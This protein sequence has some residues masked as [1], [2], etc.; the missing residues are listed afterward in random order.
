MEQAYQTGIDLDR[1]GEEFIGT[2]TTQFGKGGTSLSGSP[3]L[4]LADTRE[5]ID[6]NIERVVEQGRIESAALM[7]M[8]K[9]AEKASKSAKLSGLGQTIAAVGTAA[10]LLA[11]GPFALIGL[12]GGLGLNVAA[13]RK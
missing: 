5:R 2:I 4:V 3:L 8:A 6:R 12:A 7:R 10:T 1:E 13:A 11:G 9:K